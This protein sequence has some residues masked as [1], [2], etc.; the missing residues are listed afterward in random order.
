MGH[1]HLPQSGDDMSLSRAGAMPTSTAALVV[2]WAA[3]RCCGAPDMGN[4]LPSAF[5]DTVPRPCR[6]GHHC[7]LTHFLYVLYTNAGNL[8]TKPDGYVR[9]ARAELGQ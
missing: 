2:C 8:T 5:V 7:P 3:R 1:E 9:V 6:E 4:A